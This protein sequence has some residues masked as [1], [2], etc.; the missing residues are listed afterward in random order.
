MSRVL[1]AS[2]EDGVVTVQGLEIE[3]EI[4][5]EGLGQST[6][7]VIIDKDKAYYVASS[8]ANLKTTIEKVIAVIEDLADALTQVGTTLTS[9]GAGMTGPTTAPPPTLAADV[10][11]INAKVVEL[12]AT[13]T[14]LNTLKGDLT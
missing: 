5:T 1:E 9:I 13:K 2:C 12:N 4:F 6:G 10:L 8:S 3:A 7:I 11:A 14:E